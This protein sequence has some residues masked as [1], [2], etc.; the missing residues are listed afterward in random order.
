MYVNY[1][2][3]KFQDFKQVYKKLVTKN[4]LNKSQKVV[5]FEPVE[6]TWMPINLI[7]DKPFT[8][9]LKAKGQK[10]PLFLNFIYD[11]TSRGK[12]PELK[13]WKFNTYVSQK[14]STPNELNCEFKF[15]VTF[16]TL[17]IQKFQ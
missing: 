6:G 8:F 10:V 13:K 9:F 16:T 1:D 17:Y 15:N 14:Y 11:Q 4:P 7:K 3:L 2:S 12:K 5:I